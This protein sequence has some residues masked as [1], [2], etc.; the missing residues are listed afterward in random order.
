MRIV[1]DASSH[2]DGQPS[3]M[4]VYGQ[5]GT[6]GRALLAARLACQENPRS[7]CSTE[8]FFWTDSQ[9]TLHWIKGP[10]HRWKPFVA[11]RV[12][13]NPILTDPNSWFH[14]SGK[15]NPADLLTRGISVDALTTNSS[16]GMD[17]RFTSN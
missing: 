6:D 8:A 11:N 2:E 14:C 12:R 16:G 13:L 1:F 15:D 10:S 4:T 5:I 3:L 17:P 7:K 9:V